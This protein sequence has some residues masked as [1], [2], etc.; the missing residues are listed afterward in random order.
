MDERELIVVGGGI[1]G[2]ALAWYAARSGRSPLVLEAG[3]R[4]GGPHRGEGVGDGDHQWA[5]GSEDAVHLAQGAGQV[6]DLV[7]GVVGHH[8]VD[9]GAGGETEVR[10]GPDVALDGEA[11]LAGAPTQVVDASR[12]RIEGDCLRAAGGE[13]ERVAVTADAEFEGPTESG[14]VAAQPRP[15]FDRVDVAE[16]DRA[17]GRVHG[18]SL[19]A[20]PGHRSDR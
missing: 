14:E 17:G 5:S 4:I 16:A 20:R 13:G 10:G 6:V 19:V 15:E 3:P 2:L 1:S 9:R 8:E 18:T 11:E 7:Q 12:I